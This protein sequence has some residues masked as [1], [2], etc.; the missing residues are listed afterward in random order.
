MT[1]GDESL[2]QRFTAL[3]SKKPLLRTW[4][5][6]GGWSF[7]DVVNIPNTRAAFSDM[8][9]TLANRKAFI[10]SIGSFLRTYSFDGVDL[11]WEYPVAGDRGG[12]KADKANFVQF[13][14]E[15]RSAFGS[16]YGISLTLPASF[17]YLQG[18]DVKSIQQHVDWMNL[19]SYDLHGNMPTDSF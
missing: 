14:Q 12:I 18:F 6:V 11:N 2:Y 10:A 15:L 5:A 7:N 17:S 3:K 4:I 19:V 16:R 8:V 1:A 13:L 9:S